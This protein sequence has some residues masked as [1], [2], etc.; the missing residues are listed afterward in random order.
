MVQF[1]AA[2]IREQGVAFAVVAVKPAGTSTRSQ[3]AELAAAYSDVFP[4]VPIVL[5]SSDASGRPKFVGRRDLVNWLVRIPVQRLP[6]RTVT[7][8]QGT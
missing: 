8:G 6:W 1:D 4:G 7:V 3:A 5:M 2:L